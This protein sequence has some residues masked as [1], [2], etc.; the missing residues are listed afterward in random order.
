MMKIVIARGAG[1]RKGRTGEIDNKV[2]QVVNSEIKKEGSESKSQ[3]KSQGVDEKTKI[4]DLILA[5]KNEDSTITDEEA[6]FRAKEALNYVIN[7]SM[8]EWPGSVFLDKKYIANGA[9]GIINREHP[10]FKVYY[11]YVNELEDK[12]AVD[13]LRIILMAYIRAEDEL[14]LTLEESDLVKLREKWGY[15]IEMLIKYAQ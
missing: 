8:A 1:S 4:K 7:L 15:F 14:S 10:F 2:V 12:K 9:M 6:E 5:I 3:K 13:A 11:D